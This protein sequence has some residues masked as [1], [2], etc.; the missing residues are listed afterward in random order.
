MKAHHFRIL[1]YCNFIFNSTITGKKNICNIIRF[2]WSTNDIAS[3]RLLQLWMKAVSKLLFVVKLYLSWTFLG[4]NDKI[5]LSIWYM[6]I[7]IAHLLKIYF[8][9]IS[10]ICFNVVIRTKENNCN[11]ILFSVKRQWHSRFKTT[12]K[13]GGK[14][15]T[16]LCR[17]FCSFQAGFANSI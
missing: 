5:K 1:F 16:L 17:D 15:Q 10:F 4:K 12:V 8:T 14:T 11:V 7:L 13:E 6:T 2:K 9:I 3:F